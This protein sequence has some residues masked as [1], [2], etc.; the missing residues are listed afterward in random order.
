MGVILV[1]SLIL[2]VIVYLAVR[3][4]INPLLDEENFDTEDE[5]LE[6]IKLRDIG[7]LSNTELEEIIEFYE[8]IRSRKQKR[9]QYRKCQM[10]LEELKE[11]GYFSDEQYADK[12]YMLKNHFNRW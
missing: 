10:I 9:E 1:Y 6:L 3:L 12:I 7:V 5:E 11:M 2:F 4:A 8:R